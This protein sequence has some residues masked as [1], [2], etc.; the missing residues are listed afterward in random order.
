MKPTSPGR[1]E[2]LTVLVSEG[3]KLTCLV[4]TK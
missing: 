4:E 1:Y 2:I 3:D